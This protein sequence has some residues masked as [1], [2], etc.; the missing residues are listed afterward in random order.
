MTL[1]HGRV[2]DAIVRLITNDDT[3]ACPHCGCKHDVSDPDVSHQVVSYWGDEPHEMA[4]WSCDNDF[5]VRES[6][7]RKFTAAKTVE[8]LDEVQ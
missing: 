8:E 4:C 7:V 3:I 5:I 2:S 1:D 6:V